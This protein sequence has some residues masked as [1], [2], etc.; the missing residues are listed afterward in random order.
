MTIQ[1][2]TE[3]QAHLDASKDELRQIL[4]TSVRAERELVVAELME[5]LNLANHALK[6][7][8][9]DSKNANER[10]RL[11]GKAEGVR[12]ALGYVGEALR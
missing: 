5:R 3:A 12:L 4:R 1:L 2:S 8:A 6:T 9:D 11:K 7:L 10:I